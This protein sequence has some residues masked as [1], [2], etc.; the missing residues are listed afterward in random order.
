MGS[1]FGRRR[2]RRLVRATCLCS[3]LMRRAG[4]SGG[5]PN[6]ITPTLTRGRVANVIVLSFYDDG[7]VALTDNEIGFAENL[8]NGG[9]RDGGRAGGENCAFRSGE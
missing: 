3:R 2:V 6:F 5:A 4:R 1:I 8:G 9:R 7:I